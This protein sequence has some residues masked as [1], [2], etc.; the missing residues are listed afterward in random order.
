LDKSGIQGLR[1]NIIRAIYCKST[2]NFKLNGDIFEATPLKLGTRQGCP[3]SPYLFNIVLEVQA[4]AIRQQKEIRDIQIGKE[5][6]KVSLFAG[7]MIVY[8]SKILPRTSADK[9][10]Q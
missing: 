6:I 3:L 1:L 2:I 7:D 8:I 10:L 5:E 4:T 9:Q